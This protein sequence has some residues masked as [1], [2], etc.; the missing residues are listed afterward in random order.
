MARISE[1]DIEQL[2]AEISVQC[3]V[4][5]AGIE[6]KKAGRDLMGR[7][8][9]HAGDN[10]PSR[11]GGVIDNVLHQQMFYWYDLVGYRIREKTVQAGVVCKDNHLAYDALGRLRWASGP[12]HCHRR[13]HATCA[14]PLCKLALAQDP[15]MPQRSDPPISPIQGELHTY[16]GSCHCGAVTFEVATTLLPAGRCNCS[17]CRRKGA[18]MAVARPEDFRLLSGEDVLTR[19]QFNTRI[20]NHYFCKICGIYTFHYPRM[21]QD[22][23]RVNVGSLEGVDVTAL[24]GGLYDGASLSIVET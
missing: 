13:A 23:I 20:A 4:E 9:F 22:I 15:A 11:C 1:A 7:C 8:P 18:V 16:R 14:L 12:G 17:L 21:R 6:L 10:E 24:Q 3:L 19:Y 5:A 2:K